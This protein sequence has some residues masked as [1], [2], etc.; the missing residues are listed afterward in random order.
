MNLFV[1]FA[2]LASSLGA[3]LVGFH[4]G[5]IATPI[6]F[7]QDEFSLTFFQQGLVVSFLLI[8]A[9]FGSL[10][11][12]G[13]A[14][15]FGRKA[16]LFLTVV[17]FIFGALF[18]TYA[19]GVF[20]LLV[21]RFIAGLGVGIASVVVPLYIAEIAPPE[22]RGILGSLNQLFIGIG[23]LIAYLVS[24]SYLEE[25]GWRTMFL[26]GF[27]LALVQGVFLI[28]IPRTPPW[29][30]E[31]GEKKAA[32]EVLAKLK[33]KE[34]Q[35]IAKEKAPLTWSQLFQE[36]HRK[37]L[38]IGMGISLF[39]Q[40]TGINTV[41]YFAPRIFQYGGGSDLHQ[42]LILSLIF[43][44]INV[45]A[46]LISLWFVDW[47]GRRPL[48]LIGFGGMAVSLALLG[49]SFQLGPFFSLIAVISY[50]S[51]FAVSVGPCTW[52][53]ISEIFPESARGRGMGISIF[54]NWLA[55]Y[56]IAF[57]FLPLVELVSISI[58]FW[59]YGV[60]SIV[61]F[62]FVWKKVP[63]TKGKTLQEIQT[64]WQK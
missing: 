10:S 58:V 5:I 22:K 21:G 9:A 61:A 35:L 17:L 16:T 7:L 52:L 15:L 64:F 47:L 20:S 62:F 36:G 32:K 4:L 2:A 55:N 56:L 14:D 34:S 13:L 28:F 29:L 53:L 54:M 44:T 12:G 49:F 43:A 25:G 41:I 45:L 6:F 63:E 27:F 38:F 3:L 60:I 37:A 33:M 40:I 19:K 59:L 23:I 51:F 50:I 18:L 39:Q 57:S 48:F 26:F 8:A 11:G 46:T 42:A 24:F 30:I 1:L 31:H